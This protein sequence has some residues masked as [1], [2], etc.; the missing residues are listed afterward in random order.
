MTYTLSS[1][2]QLG[3][4]N[5]GRGAQLRVQ[6]LST[7]GANVGAPIAATFFELGNGDYGWTHDAFP[8]GFR[9]F[10]KVTDDTGAYLATFAINPQEVENP[11][12]KTS[13]A[14]SVVVAAIEGAPARATVRTPQVNYGKLTL[15]QGDDYILANGTELIFTDDGWPVVSVG[16]VVDLRITLNDRKVTEFVG[17]ISD[18]DPKTAYVEVSSLVTSAMQTGMPYQFDLRLLRNGTKTTLTSGS[19][20]LT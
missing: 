11:D 17:A 3:A 20:R 5:A 1:V 16:E 6:L 12:I 13:L 10:A 8:D 15:A 19:L 14:Q 4:K 9:G 7:T 18:D 2:I